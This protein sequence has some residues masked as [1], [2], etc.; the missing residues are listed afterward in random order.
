MAKCTLV[1]V[2]AES[3]YDWDSRDSKRDE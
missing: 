1:S 3:L 2:K